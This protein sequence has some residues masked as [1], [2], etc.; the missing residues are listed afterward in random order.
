MFQY[1][2]LVGYAEVIGKV[3]VIETGQVA[4]PS[5]EMA[6]EGFLAWADEDTHADP[7]GNPI[8]SSLPTSIWIG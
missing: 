1:T 4:V 2:A 5:V 7:G 8:F 3:K 6:Y